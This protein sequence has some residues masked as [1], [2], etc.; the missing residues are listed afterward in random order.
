[1]I[2]SISVVYISDTEDSEVDMD[3]DDHDYIP[4]EDEEDDDDTPDDEEDEDKAADEPVTGKN[5][6]ALNNYWNDMM[7]QRVREKISRSHD[8]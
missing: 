2:D 8:S 6:E 4:D 5:L 7:E 3:A 1:M